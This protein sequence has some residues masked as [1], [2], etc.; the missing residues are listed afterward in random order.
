METSTRYLPLIDEASLHAAFEVAPE[1]GAWE[2]ASA[3]H[4]SGT[5]WD[6]EM[7]LW[8]SGEH[9]LHVAF[10]GPTVT[11]LSDTELDRERERL[12][13]IRDA[14]QAALDLVEGHQRFRKALR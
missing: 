9:R 14:A 8:T 4:V 6:M 12:I 11:G 2:I 13:R 7:Q 1:G 3:R 5:G 10:R